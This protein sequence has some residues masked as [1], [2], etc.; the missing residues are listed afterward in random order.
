[1]KIFTNSNKQDIYLDDILQD[2]NG[3]H[4]LIIYCDFNLQYKMKPS[5]KYSGNLNINKNYKKIGDLQ[6]T[7]FKEPK[8]GCTELA[9]KSSSGDRYTNR[10]QKSVFKQMNIK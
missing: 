1:M 4:F 8:E 3:N 10:N 6:S 5:L 2:E 9:S 7:K